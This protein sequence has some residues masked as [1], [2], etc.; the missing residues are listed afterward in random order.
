MTLN[1]K[2]YIGADNLYY[3]L[4]TQDDADAYVAGTPAYLAPLI[5]VSVK[6]K[7]NSKVQYA[8]N[9]PFDSLSS[10][11]ESEADVEITGLPSDL[12][13]TILGK[14]W[15]ETN[16]RMYDNGGTPPYVA[17]GYR[18]K[19]SGGGYKYY[20][21]LK[22][23]FSPFDEDTATETETPDPK[24]TKL[25]LRALRTIKTFALSAS[26]TDTAKR[27]VGDD[28]HAGFSAT[29]WWAAVQ[30]PAY[31]AP[32]ALTC[33]PSPAD[34]ATGVAVTISPTLTF[35][36]AL[37]TGVTG[38]SLVT[39]GGDVIASAITIDAAK[40]VVTINPNSNIG[41]ST[42]HIITVS[43]AIDVYGQALAL[44]AYNFTTA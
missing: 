27:V 15:D 24:T 5:N 34:A 20:W 19:K 30:V 44:T 39:A 42:V 33:T 21:Y 31:S 43:G 25:K 16:G 6:P 35:N 40:K 23:Q 32:S 2:S 38:I 17:L 37:V 13:A 28:S 12:Q 29:N 8:D 10:E 26:L 9:Q 36:N 3:A 41:A 22:C 18:A 14:V 7:T 11:G 4:V 1:N